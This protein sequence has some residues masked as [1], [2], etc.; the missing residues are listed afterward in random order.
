MAL[1]SN[2]W[3][4]DYR[5]ARMS[6]FELLDRLELKPRDLSFELDA[7]SPFEL[8]VPPHFLSLMEK[9]N[10]KDPLFLQVVSRMEERRKS[11]WTSRD[12]LQE[13]RVRDKAGV[14]RKY[15]GRVLIMLS[16][17]CAIHCR[18]CFRRHVDYG[19]AIVSRSQL[20]EVVR[21]VES[22]RSI[23]EVILS[24]G[25]PFSLTDEKLFAV[26]DALGGIES[27]STIRIHTR[28]LTAVPSRL[29]PEIVEKL[30]SIPKRLVIVVHTNHP[31]ELDAIVSSALVQLVKGGGLVLNQA[32][33]LAGVNDRSDVLERH[34]WKLHEARVVPYYVHL[35]DRVEGAEHFEVPR[36]R[37]VELETSLRDRLPG[38]LVPRFVREIPGA[39]HKTPLAQLGSEEEREIER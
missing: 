4:S 8:M 24:G 22:D 12:P 14:L 1:S 32:V 10:A 33:L 29:T 20:V 39:L 17:A 9:G 25:D 35:L 7:E 36:R 3:Q 5:R 13:E 34:S 23:R 28:T 16:G 18:Y 11:H 2:D 26:L 37:A 31:N 15:S 38:Y 19:N 27:I 6:V 21:S 30:Q